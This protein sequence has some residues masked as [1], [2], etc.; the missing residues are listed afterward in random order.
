MVNS[1]V[2][3][4]CSREKME[5]RGADDSFH[6]HDSPC[7]QNDLPATRLKVLLG[8]KMLFCKFFLHRI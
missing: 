5:D 7:P 1:A 4:G 3:L 8:E 2:G 6:S